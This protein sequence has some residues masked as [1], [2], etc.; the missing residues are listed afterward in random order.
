MKKKLIYCLL[1]IGV[2]ASTACNKKEWKETVNTKVYL[3]A[4]GTSIY[5]G[6]NYLEIDTFSISMNNFSLVGNRIQAE[7]IFLVN[8]ATTNGTFVGTNSQLSLSFDIPQGTY[9]QLQLSMQLSGS[10]SLSIRGTYH[11][12]SGATKLVLIDFENQDYIVKKILQ[13]G[14]ETV[15]I[16]KDNPGSIVLTLDANVLFADLN[17]SYWNGASTSVV[18]GQ[19]A[20]QISNSQNANMHSLIGNKISASLAYDYN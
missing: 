14:S 16:D 15:L 4:I 12:A 13:S 11:L 3:N 19:N 7:D 10:S 1:F 17:P 2:F 5:F 9:E 6:V 20:I 18:G 8:P